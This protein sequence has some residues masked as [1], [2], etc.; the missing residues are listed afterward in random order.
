V[1][2]SDPIPPP[3]TNLPTRS[4]EI[5]LFSFATLIAMLSLATR[6]SGVSANAA[7][8]TLGAFALLRE[9][10]SFLFLGAWWLMLFLEGY[11]L[12]QVRTIRPFPANLCSLTLA[13]SWALTRSPASR[14]PEPSGGRSR[15]P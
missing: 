7:T 13:R 4:A 12:V 6:Y 3:S 10:L 5:F 1:A 8:G 2:K 9:A 14:S 15:S 11:Y